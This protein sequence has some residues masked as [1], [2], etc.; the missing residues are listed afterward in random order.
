MAGMTFTDDANSRDDGCR[1]AGG[2]RTTGLNMVVKRVMD[3]LRA[4]VAIVMLA[5]LMALIALSS[6]TSPGPVRV[7][8]ERSG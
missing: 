7:P 6:R 2:T 8:A 4:S 3:I 5:P 1:A